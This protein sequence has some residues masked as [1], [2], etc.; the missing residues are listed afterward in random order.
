[1]QAQGKMGETPFAPGRRI[2]MSATPL[3]LMIVLPWGA[4]IVTCAI[5]AFKM[6]YLYPAVVTAFC[7][8]CIL[9]WL[10]SIPL[11]LWARAKIAEPT[12]YTYLVFVLGIG[13]IGGPVCGNWIYS[14][15]MEPYYRVMDLK[16][17]TGVDVSQEK[18][19]SMLDVG[20]AEFVKDNKL[21]EMRSWHFKHHNTY[22]VAP[23]VSESSKNPA[24]GSYDFWAVGKDCCSLTTSDF[25]CGVWMKPHNNKVIRA[26]SDEDLPFYRLAVQ[27]AETLY[28]VV[29]ANPVFFKW[30]TD[31][32]E[33]VESWEHQG[34]KNFIFCAVSALV[35]FLALL[36]FAAWRYAWLGRSNMLSDFDRRYY[37]PASSYGAA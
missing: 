6:K 25:R 5:S 26:T 20:I 16:V 1:M 18:G 3:I 31:P 10:T 21:D 4:F 12:W 36:T 14:S 7:S 23:I 2:K 34:F 8:L 17:L 11:A 22:C 13:V 33:E 35:V 32:K 15:L 29:S 28:G 24:T 27:Q 37:L 30:S 9:L 19:D